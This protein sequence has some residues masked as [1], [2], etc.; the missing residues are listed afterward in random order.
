M[1]LGGTGHVAGRGVGERGVVD[2]LPTA[3]VELARLLTRLGDPTTLFVVVA[4]AYLLAGR[5]GVRPARAAVVVALALGALPAVLALKHAAA[6]PRPPGAGVDGYGFPSGH[7]LGATVV[8]GGLAALDRRRRR[9]ASVGAAVLVVVVAASR[10]VVGVHYLVDVVAGVVLGVGYLAVALR[11]GPGV[12]PDRVDAADVRRTF[13]LGV[14]VA[15]VAVGTAAGR[16][17]AVALGA[18]V[19]GASGWRI[20]A[21]TARTGGERATSTRLVA[22]LVAVPV[23]ALAVRTVVAGGVTTPVAAVL[24]GIVVAT[25]VASPR[26][27]GEKT[28]ES[29]G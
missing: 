20:A 21:G 9:P 27:G 11:L 28:C 14:G 15:L 29:G 8:Y 3:A 12:A 4:A 7:A 19:G 26:V 24:A 1:S 22:A 16:E 23:A 2:T 17:T 25:L 18:A 5:R 6:L 13:V 10:V